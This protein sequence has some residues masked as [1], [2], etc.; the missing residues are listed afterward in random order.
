[1]A[2]RTAAFKTATRAAAALA[3][4]GGVAIGLT[5]PPSRTL[6]LTTAEQLDTMQ[7]RMEKI[8]RVIGNHHFTPRINRQTGYQT[9]IT[10]QMSIYLKPRV[11]GAKPKPNEPSYTTDEGE[12]RHHLV[13][14]CQ[15]AILLPLSL[16]LS[17]THTQ[18][19]KLLLTCSG[20]ARQLDARGRYLGDVP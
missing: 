12:V 19:H 13:V 6:G 8:E 1:M 11:S 18:T 4:G 14:G 5:A 9:K 3:A 16:S 15:I 17:H 2:Y 7:Y 10:Q 20:Q